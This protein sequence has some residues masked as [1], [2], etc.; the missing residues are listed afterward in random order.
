M[1]G[2]AAPQRLPPHPIANPTMTRDLALS[3]LKS[4]NNGDQMLQILDTIILGNSVDESDELGADA[5]LDPI[6]L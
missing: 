2:T 5:T 1:T 3:L 6:A 4:G